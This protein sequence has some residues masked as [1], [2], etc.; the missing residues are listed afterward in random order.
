VR[1]YARRETHPGRL[2][3]ATWRLG[4]P[5]PGL[6][7]D[8]VEEWDAGYGRLRRWAHMLGFGGHFSTKSRRYSTTLGAL[9]Q[10]CRDWRRRHHHDSGP[11][12]DRRD[13]NDEETTV[14]IGALTFAG[15]GWHTT[16]DALL[17]NTAAAKAREHRQTAREELTTRYPDH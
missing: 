5:P 10:A 12:Q 4:T 2:T 15:I 17:A 11:E 14:G 13:D 8:E 1:R 16:A 7:Q 3:E 6:K 9:R